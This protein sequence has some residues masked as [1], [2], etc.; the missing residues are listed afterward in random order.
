MNWKTR[1]EIPKVSSVDKIPNRKYVSKQSQTRLDSGQIG[2]LVAAYQAG[3]TIKE[4]ATQF[5]VHRTTVSKILERRGVPKRY[6]PLTTEQIEYAIRAY[7]AGSSSKMIGDLLGV[8][9]STIWRT[10]RREGVKMR[11]CHGRN[12]T[13]SSH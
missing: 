6:R 10:L 13:Q 12:V 4:L 7:Q 1:E 2:D 11:D 9:A 3:S 8:N 5:Q